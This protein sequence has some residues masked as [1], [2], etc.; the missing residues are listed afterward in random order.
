M[1]DSALLE[2]SDLRKTF[3]GLVALYDLSVTVE[4]ETI[5]GIIGPNGSGKSTFF[6]TISGVYEPDSGTVRFDSTDITGWSPHRIA[7]RGMARTFQIASPFEELTVR[8]NLRV[9]ETPDRVDDEA[10]A[11]ELLNRLDIDHVADNEAREISGGQRKLLELARVLMLDPA[12]VLLDEPMAG[13]NPA[14]VDRILDFLQDMNEEG[15]TF[16]LI[17]HDM[18]VIRRVSDTI[19]VF[20][21]GSVVA[22]GEFQDIRQD[23]RVREA[24]L[25][26]P[27][28]DTSPID[29][30][31]SDWSSE[32]TPRLS[33][34]NIVAGY[35]QHEVLH[36][37]SIT[38]CD[39]VT[40]VFGPNGSGKST[41]LKT[42]NGLVSPWE[43]HVDH[44]GADITGCNPRD[45]V[46]NGIVT[47]SQDGGVFS[48]MTVKENLKLG[49]YAIEDQSVV[50][51][52][53]EE[54]LE[55][56]PDLDGKLS[57]P[58]KSLSG[59][60]QMMLSFG[61][62]MMTGA[63]TFLLDEPS[64]GLAPSLVDDVFEMVEQFADAEGQVILVEQNV[65][66]AMRI[67]D[68]V[69]ILAQG[70]IQFEG[71]PDELSDQTEIMDVYL[72]MG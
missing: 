40:C 51:D 71:T 57:D 61:Q 34:S 62:A 10:R 36:D 58:A 27:D 52:R 68:Y 30:G 35:G 4:E 48:S 33:A 41:L 29:S 53:V 47:V 16:I 3:G 12:L 14:L 17:E 39:G 66:A 19:T 7:R 45:G 46:R 69:Y 65:S 25:G 54:V 59:G 72:G 23:D 8:E 20:D 18:D 55:T 11:T 21:Q 9:V 44:D 50:D 2:V 6:N 67:A 15:T 13:V 1:G 22:Q 37:V 64:A 70:E 60:Q 28:D 56:F 38:S 32:E 42:I 24:Y 49:A 63:D 43:G 26:T 31:G 5:H